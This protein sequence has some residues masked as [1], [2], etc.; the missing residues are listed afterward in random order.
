MRFKRSDIPGM[1]VAVIGPV[2]LFFLL[3]ESYQLWH[4]HGSPILGILS[5]HLAIGGGLIGGFARFIKAKDAVLGLLGALVLCI[6]GVLALQAS[7]NDDVFAS[8]LKILGI[9]I[10]GILNVVIV[11]QILVYGVNPILVRRD[12]RAAASQEQA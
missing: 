5:V 6:V 3:L 4:H 7:G 2:G 11:W 12:E 9:L 10:F 8:V 1:L